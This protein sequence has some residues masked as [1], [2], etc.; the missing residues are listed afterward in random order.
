MANVTINNTTKANWLHIDLGAYASTNNDAVH[1][2][3]IALIPG[4]C[5][6]RVD[7]LQDYIELY[8]GQGEKPLYLCH[9][10][11]VNSTTLVVDTVN[12]VAPINQADLLT[13]ILALL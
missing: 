10:I 5:T 2:R 8:L 11:S 1:Y 13:K 12:G 4:I 3:P 7:N 6:G 9:G